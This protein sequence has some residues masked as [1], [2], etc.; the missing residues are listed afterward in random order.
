VNE[1]LLVK[2]LLRS[3]PLVCSMLE[4]QVSDELTLDRGAVS[5]AGPLVGKRGRGRPSGLNSCGRRS[6]DSC[7][8]GRPL[9]IL[10]SH[11][12]SAIAESGFRVVLRE[13]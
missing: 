4:R 7:V 8:L 11:V 5:S 13:A 3:V 1:L 12:L 10:R 2:T 9:L 6:I